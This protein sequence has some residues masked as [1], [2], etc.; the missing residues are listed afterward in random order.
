MTQNKNDEKARDLY[1][2]L[3]TTHNITFMLNL[4]NQIRESIL[5]GNGAFKKLKKQWLE[6]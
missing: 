5:K 6:S 1:E 3:V 2:K 4:T